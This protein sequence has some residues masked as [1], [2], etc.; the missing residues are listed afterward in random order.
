MDTRIKIQDIEIHTHILREWFEIFQL[1]KPLID[2]FNLDDIL[3]KLCNMNIN[4]CDD[5]EK[6]I[7][8]SLSMTFLDDNESFILTKDRKKSNILDRKGRKIDDDP[9]I[10]SE[11]EVYM[12]IKL[13]IN[14]GFEYFTDFV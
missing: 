6:E 7:F 14:N 2:E 11:D 13:V 1:F 10:A 4:K 3:T 9:W 12:K 5:F 8:Y